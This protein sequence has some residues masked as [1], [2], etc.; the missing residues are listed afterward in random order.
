MTR[1]ASKVCRP[2]QEIGRDFARGDRIQFTAPVKDFSVTNRG[3]AT[4]VRLG[5]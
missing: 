2:Y 3:M 4:I 1:S 5:R